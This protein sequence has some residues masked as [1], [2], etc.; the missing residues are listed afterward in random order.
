MKC[1]SETI[2]QDPAFLLRKIHSGDLKLGEK[3]GDT[4][5]GRRQEA[6]T[7]QEVRRAS[8]ECR[9]GILQERNA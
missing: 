1:F 3:V 5:G 7:D 4:A 9:S 2:R 6:G 8:K